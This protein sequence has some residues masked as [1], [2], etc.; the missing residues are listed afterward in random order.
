MRSTCCRSSSAAIDLAYFGGKTYREVSEALGIPEGT[1]KSRSG[2]PCARS[3]RPSR[4]KEVSGEESSRLT[5]DQVEALLGAYALDACEPDEV[6]AIEAALRAPTSPRKRVASSRWRHGSAPRTHCVRP[7]VSRRCSAPR[8]R[9]DA[10]PD[11]VVELYESECDQFAATLAELPRGASCDHRQRLSGRDLV[12]HVAAQ[13]SLL[14][15]LVG[16]PVIDAVTETDID[17]RTDAMLTEFEDRSLDDIVA[18]WRARST[19]IGVGRRP[20][21]TRWRS[22]AGWSCRATTRSSCGRSRPGCTARTSAGSA[23]WRP[24]SRRRAT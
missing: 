10:S 17:A 7:R 20:A 12:T 9:I 3:R 5:D 4:R 19:R 6:V 24:E 23:T 22:G 14:A 13:E 15:Q 21:P 16:E 1:A 11:P 8:W 2:S 18:S